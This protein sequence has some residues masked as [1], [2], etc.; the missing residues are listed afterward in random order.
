MLAPTATSWPRRPRELGGG[1]AFMTAPP[2]PFVPPALQGQPAVG[3]V[4]AWFGDIERGP[5]GAGAPARRSPP[6]VDMVQ[7]MPYLVLQTLTDAG[8]A[9]RAGATTGARRTW[10]RSP[11]E[12]IDT[13]LARAARGHLAHHPDHHPAPGRGGGG[14]GRGRHGA[15][16]PRRRPGNTTATGSGRMREDAR[17]IDWVRGTEQAMRPFTSGGISINFVSEAG[18]DRVRAAFG[19]AKYR[20]LVALKDQYDPENLFRLNQNVVPSLQP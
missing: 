5:A 16:R 10:V 15:R 11:I 19:E 20:R 8:T 1:V 3:V 7:P 17:H 13:L 2:A 4:V 9:V 18:N 6:A 14:R 12:A